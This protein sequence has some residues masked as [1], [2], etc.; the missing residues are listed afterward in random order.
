MGFIYLRSLEQLF[1]GIGIKRA[2]F[3]V[4]GKCPLFRQLL[5]RL[6]RRSLMVGGH[7]RS[8][9]LEIPSEPDDFLLLDRMIASLT[10]SW[11]EKKG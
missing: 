2:A 9:K 7:L 4:T 10:S 3:Q 6:A 5:K 8:M 11:E 1:L